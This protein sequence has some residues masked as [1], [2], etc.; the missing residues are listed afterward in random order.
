MTRLQVGEQLGCQGVPHLGVHEFNSSTAPLE[1][2]VEEQH[3]LVKVPRSAV[4]WTPEP[5]WVSE[6]ELSSRWVLVQQTS[7]GGGLPAT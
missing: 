7:V 5:P 2:P 4:D 6:D 1:A 3:L